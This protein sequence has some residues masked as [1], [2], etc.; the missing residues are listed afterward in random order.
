MS[1]SQVVLIL[2]LTFFGCLAVIVGI[3]VALMLSEV[4]GEKRRKK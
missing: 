1:W 4:L 3:V 2:G